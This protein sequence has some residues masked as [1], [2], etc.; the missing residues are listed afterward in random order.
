M[1]QGLDRVRAEM[2]G[3]GP[4][5]QGPGNLALG[6][7]YCYLEDLK[8]A[9]QVLQAA[10]EGGYRTPEVAYALSRAACF[11]YFRLLDRAD[12]GDLEEPLEP[13]LAAHRREARGYFEQSRGQAWEPQDLGEARLAYLEADFARSVRHARA[14]FRE[15]PWLYEAKMQEAFSLDAMGVARQKAGELGAARR[16]YQEAS[17]AAQV[18]RGIG[19]SDPHCYLAD[20]EWRFHW[21]HNP[22]L[23]HGER[24]AL[25]GAAE[26]L[27]DTLLELHPESPRALCS[28]VFVLVRRAGFRAE[29]GL[30]PEPDLRQAERLLAPVS[31]RPAFQRMVDLKRR[32]IREVRQ[33]G[34]APEPQ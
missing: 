16:L 6:R 30:D 28:K 21:L 27:A 33:A 19:R 29:R 23:G 7:G 15:Q 12:M 10:W 2:A 13:A 4:E 32:Q 31:A 20:M 17:L 34:A 3:L 1:Q 5:A 22:H 18:A 26:A 11:A 8:H 24:M 25:L 14:A 9:R